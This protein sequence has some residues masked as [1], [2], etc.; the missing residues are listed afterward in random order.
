MQASPRSSRMARLLAVP[1]TLNRANTPSSLGQ[2]LH[3]GLG[4]ARVVL[5]V[6]GDDLDLAC[7]RCPRAPGVHVL[8]VG[9][10]ALGDLGEGGVRSR[11]RE[12]RPER[13]RVAGDA[14]GVVVGAVVEVEM[15]TPLDARPLRGR[16][17]SRGGVL[18]AA[19]A[20][21]GDQGQD[22]Q[23]RT[24]ERERVDRIMFG[25]PS[26]NAPVP[27]VGD[28]PSGVD[29][30]VGAG[31]GAILRRLRR[32]SP[33]RRR[34]ALSSRL[35][36]PRNPPGATIMRRMSMPPNSTGTARR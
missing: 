8:E 30:A 11:L 17:L 1:T 24:I 12:A 34:P 2:P 32:P 29:S 35:R 28:P 16:P 15:V 4:L 33:K 10:V 22:R 25:S 6:L 36:P 9:L 18:A 27:T 13:D 14:L 19:T 21:G 31:L 5:V 26:I 23:Q 20:R 7:R 3:V